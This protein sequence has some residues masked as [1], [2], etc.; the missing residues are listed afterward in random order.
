[1]QVLLR[2]VKTKLFYVGEG[3]WSYKTETAKDF[4]TL[5]EAQRCATLEKLAG[6]ELVMLNKHPHWEAV[7]PL[8]EPSASTMFSN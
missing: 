8:K 6:I 2:Q 4:R 1:M 3:Q 7:W 5:A